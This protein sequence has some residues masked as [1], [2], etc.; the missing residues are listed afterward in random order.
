[1]IWKGFQTRWG[2]SQVPGLISNSILGSFSS[3]AS[4]LV[5]VPWLATKPKCKII[6]KW[7]LLSERQCVGETVQRRLRL[8]YL[9]N[10]L[11]LCFPSSYDMKTQLDS[12][13]QQQSS[14]GHLNT[15]RYLEWEVMICTFGTVVHAKWITFT[16]IKRVVQSILQCFT[17]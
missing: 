17:S 2:W 4:F 3:P 10:K 7:H 12:R 16:C 6:A 15:N 13:I 11:F 9:Q 1:M 5:W 14:W 8:I